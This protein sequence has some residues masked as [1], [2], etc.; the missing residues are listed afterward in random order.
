MYTYNDKLVVYEAK[1]GDGIVDGADRFHIKNARLNGD[2]YLN[3]AITYLGGNGGSYQKENYPI[4]LNTLGKGH[5]VAI[6][7]VD[8]IYKIR[9]IGKPKTLTTISQVVT[10]TNPGLNGASCKIRVADRIFESNMEINSGGLQGITLRVLDDGK[11]IAKG[12]VEYAVKRAGA[13]AHLGIPAKFLTFGV[14]W[15]TGLIKVS[16]EDSHGTKQRTY[17]TPFELMN[18]I[19]TFRRSY[20]YKGNVKNKK[21]VMPIEVDGQ[22]LKLWTDW[23]YYNQELQFNVDRNEDLLF[24]ELNLDANNIVTDLDVKSGNEA[25]SGM[26]IWDMITNTVEFSELTKKKLDDPISDIFSQIGSAYNLNGDYTLIGGIGFLKDF[27]RVVSQTARGFVEI[28]SENHFITKGEDGLR[29]GNYFTEYKHHSGKIIKVGYD[30]A[31]DKSGRSQTS[32]KHPISGLNIMSHCALALDWSM[33]ENVKGDGQMSNISIVY[34]EGREFTEKV[35]NGMN[36]DSN[37]ISTDL[38]RTSSHKMATQGAYLR[39]PLTCAKYICKV[40]PV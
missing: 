23:D 19:S 15:A 17:Q 10:Q 39:R 9:M 36:S 38:D 14:K 8:N 22:I 30:S 1:D 7:Q 27:D 24:S 35:I 13:S 37:V 4:L 18:Q 29:Y 16:Q 40:N 26:G 21:L 11:V 33:V 20:T 3:S 2:A 34:E 32:G 5:K 31:F 6:N 25:R 12:I 28:M